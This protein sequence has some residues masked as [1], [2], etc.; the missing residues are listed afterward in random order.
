M[1][2]RSSFDATNTRKNARAAACPVVSTKE[3]ECGTWAKKGIDRTERA[4]EG[5]G[6]SRRRVGGKRRY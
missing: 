4:V 5:R 6:Q 3:G 2:C 1:H